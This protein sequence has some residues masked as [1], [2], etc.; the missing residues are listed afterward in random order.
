MYH[1]QNEGKIHNLKID[2]R[3]FANMAKLKYLGMT[4]K[5]HYLIQDEIK[6]RLNS[7]RPNACCHLSS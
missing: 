1:R 3:Y 2:N 5:N 7:G 6:R 4:V